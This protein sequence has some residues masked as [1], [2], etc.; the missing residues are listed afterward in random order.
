MKTFQ[1]ESEEL[2]DLIN[3]IVYDH[4][5]LNWEEKRDIF[6]G[7]LDAGDGSRWTTWDEFLSWFDPEI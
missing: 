3:R 6:R 4:G 2:L 5:H 7:V 1:S